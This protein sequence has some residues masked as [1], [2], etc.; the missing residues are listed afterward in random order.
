MPL[1]AADIDISLAIDPQAP[2]FDPLSWASLVVF[3]ND[4]VDA[5]ASVRV[6]PNAGTE[7]IYATDCLLQAG[8]ELGDPVLIWGEG[9]VITPSMKVKRA[10]VSKKYAHIIDSLYDKDPADEEQ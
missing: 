4:L 3:F 8:G 6:L 1:C 7:G 2:V 10:A 9:G 5:G